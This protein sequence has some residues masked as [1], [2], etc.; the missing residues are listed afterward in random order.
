MCQRGTGAEASVNVNY[1][2]SRW[3]ALGLAL[4]QTHGITTADLAT[5][6]YRGIDPNIGPV[7]LG[8]CAQDTRIPWKI[9]LRER[10]HHAAGAGTND[11]HAN[12]IP[13]R[14]G[15]PDPSVLH[16][17]LLAVSGLHYDVWAKSSDLEAPLRIQHSQ[18]I[19]GRRCQK[20]D[21][22]TV[23]KR[24][25]RQIEVGDG[26]PVVEALNIWPVFLRCGRRQIGRCGQCHLMLE[27]LGKDLVDVGV[28]TIDERAIRQGD[29]DWRHLHTG[30]CGAG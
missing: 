1:R 19:E 17:T 26:V 6:Q 16:E 24:T 7:V 3:R 20:M 14:E 23:E 28:V 10:R 18:S 2:A 9:A 12:G 29:A 11:A 22:G 5:L 25:F 8:R 15:L 13:E 4:L 30:S 21:E 27:H